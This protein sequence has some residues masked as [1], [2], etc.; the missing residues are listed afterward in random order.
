VL[1]GH[2]QQTCALLSSPS[3]GS[4][5]QCVWPTQLSLAADKDGAQFKLGVHVEAE[6]WVALPGNRDAWPQQVQVDGK[7]AV[8]LD[9]DGVPTLRL[10]AGDYVVQGG[11]HW[12]ARPARLQMPESIAL[13]DLT[14]DG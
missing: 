1:H 13:I 14:V 7:P 12:D 9:R 5:H 8:V 6:S 4:G 2:E 10:A 11:M 3:G